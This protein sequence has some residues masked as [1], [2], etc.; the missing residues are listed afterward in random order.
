MILNMV[1][2]LPW[3]ESPSRAKIRDTLSNRDMYLKFE[4]EVVNK[5]RIITVVPLD[6]TYHQYR[7]CAREYQPRK[8]HQFY[9]IKR[10]LE[11]LMKKVET[12]FMVRA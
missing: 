7:E 5:S 12:C 8:D 10:V 3:Y 1:H 2:W 9:S 4:V 11:A 6:L